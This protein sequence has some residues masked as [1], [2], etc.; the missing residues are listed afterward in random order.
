MGKADS[1]GW[2]GKLPASSDSWRCPPCPRS[3][4]TDRPDRVCAPHRLQLPATHQASHSQ[5]NLAFLVQFVSA[6]LVP[7]C[8]SARQVAGSL[9]RQ[10]HFPSCGHPADLQPSL[11]TWVQPVLRP[12]SS[13]MHRLLPGTK[14]E[15]WCQA[16]PKPAAV[17]V[18]PLQHLPQEHPCGECLPGLPTLSSRSLPPTLVPRGSS[19]EEVSADAPGCKG[20]GLASVS[21]PPRQSSP[22]RF[23]SASTGAR[24][25]PLHSAPLV[26]RATL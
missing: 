1:C 6:C 12:E 9:H 16:V 11:L 10:P 17:Q 14:C 15:E 8:P 3:L 25:Q 24:T 26:C 23:T 7:R 2:S 20:G 22:C 19:A 5:L 18:V 4:P 21:A 13:Y